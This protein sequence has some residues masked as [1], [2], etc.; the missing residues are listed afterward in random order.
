MTNTPSAVSKS[1]S[2]G[3]I[4]P[5]RDYTANTLRRKDLASDPIQQFTQWLQDA[6][7]HKILDATAMMLATADSSGQPHSRIVLLK[8]FDASGFV[9][10]TYQQSDKAKQ[11]S[12]NGKASLLF[13]WCALERQVRIEGTVSK[14]DPAE[15][16]EYFY[17]RP[18]G[19]RFS[20]AAS[21]QSQPVE[22]RDVLEK[23]V[24]ELHKQY[25]DG[26]VPRP[27]AWG[28]YRLTPQ[29]LEFWQGRADRLHDRF[30]FEQASASSDWSI[31]RIQP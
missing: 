8:R 19:S 13:Y 11:L 17:S 15:A 7:D 10:Y 21:E 6:R 18:E 29:R 30:V 25:P 14:L 28:G 12:E 2:A 20:A 27:N 26:N 16:D 24:T 31:V 22:N 3:L 9:W 1:E 5:R 23:R 4:E